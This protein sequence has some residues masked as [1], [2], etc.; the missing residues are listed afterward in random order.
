MESRMESPIKSPIDSLKTK[1]QMEPEAHCDTAGEEDEEEM[2]GEEGEVWEDERLFET[3]DLAHLNHQRHHTEHVNDALSLKKSDPRLHSSHEGRVEAVGAGAAQVGEEENGECRME[4]DTRESHIHHEDFYAHDESGYDP[5]YDVPFTSD[6][7]L[8][9]CDLTLSPTPTDGANTSNHTNHHTNYRASPPPHTTTRYNN[10]MDGPPAFAA[11]APTFFHPPSPHTVRTPDVVRTSENV[12]TVDAPREQ[13]PPAA[14]MASRS[15]GVSRGGG[16]H[17]QYWDEI[18]DVDSS[19]GGQ[20][21]EGRIKNEAFLVRGITNRVTRL[22]TADPNEDKDKERGKEK[23][24]SRNKSRGSNARE[25]QSSAERVF[26]V[27]VELDDGHNVLVCAVSDAL[28]ERFLDMSAAD[29]FALMA[30]LSSK[31]EKRQAQMGLMNRFQHFHG[32]FWGSK[33]Q[34]NSTGGDA[35]EEGE[36]SVV[37]IDF[38]LDEVTNVCA[39]ILRKLQ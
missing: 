1:P 10:A 21:Q 36:P 9:T 16:P 17:L 20:E 29:H 18:A 11:A 23:E 27:H 14:V 5:F 26:Q 34:P 19:R 2:E 33:S 12:R 22:R 25:D 35:G 39:N 28:V 4:V 15:A 8:L 24:K 38:A 37:L 30:T 32:L 13:H 7:P 3:G 31:Q 6:G